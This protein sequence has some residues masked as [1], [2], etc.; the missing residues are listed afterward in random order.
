MSPAT[1]LYQAPDRSPISTQHF[2]LSSNDSFVSSDVSQMFPPSPQHQTPV[3]HQQQ[4]QFYPF[5]QT[6]KSHQQLIQSNLSNHPFDVA[7]Q[8]AS[9][10]LDQNQL[11]GQMLVTS[12]GSTPSS[13]ELYTLCENSSAYE[14]SEDTGIG[15][16]SESEQQLMGVHD[17]KWH[18]DYG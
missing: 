12:D 15:G 2:A 11:F 8:R 7:Q 6:I 9:A 1:R 10:P 17:G 3:H 13:Q 14:S 5:Q 18:T 16:L 4:H